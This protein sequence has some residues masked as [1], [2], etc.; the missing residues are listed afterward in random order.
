MSNKYDNFKTKRLSANGGSL[1]VT[2]TRIKFASVRVSVVGDFMNERYILS[3]RH[4]DKIYSYKQ[5][6]ALIAY[7]K[8]HDETPAMDNDIVIKNEDS[9]EQLVITVN[10]EEYTAIMYDVRSNLNKDYQH[11]MPADMFKGL[12]ADFRPAHKKGR[13]ITTYKN[14]SKRFMTLIQGKGKEDNDLSKLFGVLPPEYN[15]LTTDG[16]YQVWA[17]INKPIEEEFGCYWSGTNGERGLHVGN[18]FHAVNDNWQASLI[19][20]DGT[21]AAEENQD[22][23]NAA[24]VND[25]WQ[26]LTSHIEDIKTLSSDDGLQV[27]INQVHDDIGIIDTNDLKYDGGKVWVNLSHKDALV[28]HTA[29][30]FERS[31][32][33]GNIPNANDAAFSEIEAVFSFAQPV[34]YYKIAKT[35]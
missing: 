4:A 7:A 35:H 17:F 11:V 6:Q 34:G 27:S 22:A 25:F 19:H 26:V 32:Y 33:K 18:D 14:G 24:S 28:K 31:R 8:T 10:P 5:V 30:I 23:K 9:G 29:V 1:S 16:N 15:W 20:R 2:I 12:K 3:A 21:P 13:A